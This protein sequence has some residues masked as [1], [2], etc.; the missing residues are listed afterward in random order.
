M[1]NRS[2]LIALCGLAVVGWAVAPDAL[3]QDS[4]TNP[5]PQAEVQTPGEL[6]STDPSS[7]AQPSED[8]Q[9]SVGENGE[10]PPRSF[11]AEFFGNPL[12]LLLISGILFVFIVLRPQQRQMREMQNALT[13]LKKND[14]VITGSGIHGTV[15]QANADEP[16]VTLRID[17]NTGARMTVNRDSITKIVSA[18]T[19][20]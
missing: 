13:K 6:A 12:N 5:A 19:K 10:V 3:A 17:E 1:D 7:I 14:K 15:I 9:P 11:L 20:E 2:K 8:G 16:V 4:N 18:E